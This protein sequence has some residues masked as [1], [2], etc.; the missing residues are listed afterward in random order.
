MILF[1]NSFQTKITKDNTKSW[2]IANFLW[3]NVILNFS[4]DVYTGFN[5]WLCDLETIFFSRCHVL[6]TS[7]NQALK[8][9]PTWVFLICYLFCFI[10]TQQEHDV[11][12]TS[13]Q[14]PYDVATL[15]GRCSNVRTTSCS[16]WERLNL[17]L[18]EIISLVKCA[19]KFYRTQKQRRQ[20]FILYK[21]QNF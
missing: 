19:G 20:Q 11:V 5:T 13:L 6:T 10:S 12:L 21:K 14:R 17:T 7:G 1:W 4:I 3:E 8:T 2:F 16:C 15:N 18:K 9:I